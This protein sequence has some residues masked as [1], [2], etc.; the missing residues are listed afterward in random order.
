MV[1]SSLPQT[2]T[3]ENLADFIRTNRIDTRNH[4]KEFQLTDE[5]K[6][7]LAIKS[8]NAGIAIAKLKALEK[9]FKLTIKKGTPWDRAVGD[10]GDHRPADFTIPP[11]AGLDALES[12]RAYADDQISKGVREEV[13]PIY[14]LPW[15]EKE[16]VV[17]VDIQGEEWTIYTRKMT[18]IEVE[19]HGKPIL[20]ADQDVKDALEENG[21]RITEVKGKKVSVEKI[22]KPYKDKEGRPELD[23]L[24]DEEEK[25]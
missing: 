12:N 9:R 8:A 2:M 7:D 1:H 4:V 16:M 24:A 13:T 14:F 22:D 17:A 18:A 25:D 15:P 19:Q 3:P 5:E 6:R 10:G 20:K 11:T 23:L 21:L